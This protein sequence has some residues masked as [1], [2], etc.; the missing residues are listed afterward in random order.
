MPASVRRIHKNPMPGLSKLLYTAVTLI[1][2]A[3]LALVAT[4]TWRTHAYI[5]KNGRE[6]VLLV[7][8]KY[9]DSRW[10]EPVP[11]K[12]IHAYTATLAPNYDVVITT[13]QELA[14]RTQVFIRHLSL[15]DPEIDRQTGIFRPITGR[16][17]LRT[18]ADG[19]P[20]AI[21]PTVPL[22]KA[23]EKAMGNQPASQ[24][25]KPG[26]TGPDLRRSSATFVLGGANDGVFELIWNNSRATEWIV[27]GLALFLLQAFAINA[28]TLP[29]RKTRPCDEDKDFVHPSLGRIEPDT[30]RPPV[31]RIAFK[32]KP[33]ETEDGPTEPAEPDPVDRTLRLPR[34]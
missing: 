4:D 9:N 27:L 28:W 32:P 18:P 30:P 21:D 7:G 5:K 19:T 29:W 23:V 13:D 2:A 12:K 10:A 11:L 14:P 1:M 33:R 25:V 6:G 3:V 20:V 24:G 34:K 22:E 26:Q 31:T 8:Q 15:N 17:R 16:I